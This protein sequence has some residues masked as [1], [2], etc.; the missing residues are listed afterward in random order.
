MLQLNNRQ[1]NNIVIISNILADK[2]RVKIL[3]LLLENKE[4]CVSDIAENTKVSLSAVSH[5]LK[6]LEMLKI[7]SYQRKGQ[8]IC[9]YL[10]KHN[11]S[12]KLIKKMLNLRT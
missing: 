4:I 10:N 8:T 1:L 12:T 2:T 6:K 11:R 3:K 5:Q 7:V 9:Y